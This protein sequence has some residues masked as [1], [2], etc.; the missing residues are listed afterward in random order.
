MYEF[1][2]IYKENKDYIFRP[3]I[4]SIK[5]YGTLLK[6]EKENF[7]KLFKNLPYIKLVYITDENFTQ[8]SPNYLKR[9]KDETV[10]GVSRLG[11]AKK[12]KKIDEEFS[13]SEPYISSATG[14]LSVTISKKEGDKYIFLEIDLLRLLGHLK[15]IEFHPEFEKFTEIFY[16]SIGFLMITFSIF[17]IFYAIFGYLSDVILSNNFSLEAIFKPIIS[18]T[19]GLAIFD[20]AKTLLERE[21]F[22][23]NYSTRQDDSI[24]ILTHF[25][26][27]VIIALSI[28][29]LMTVFKITI[30]DYT[31]LLYALYLIAGTSI[32]II[33]LGIYIFLYKKSKNRTS[34]EE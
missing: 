8:I 29:S 23:R 33:S 24:K 26:T 28:E 6:Y 21:V 7:H 13:I 31:K 27:A 20:L 17:S 10:V 3:L 22:F 19:L 2:D 11:F 34:T 9:K 14:E 1:I 5:L 18:L 4:S 25:L 12:F 30:A 15:L 16:K 32:V